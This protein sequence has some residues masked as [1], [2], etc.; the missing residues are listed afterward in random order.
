MRTPAGHRQTM[1]VLRG[2]VAHIAKLGLASG[3]V[4]IKPAVRVA[5]PRTGVVIALLTVEV[6]AIIIIIITSSS[7]LPSLGRLLCFGME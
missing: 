1:P 3:S 7:P 4:V 2:G 5:G 6:A